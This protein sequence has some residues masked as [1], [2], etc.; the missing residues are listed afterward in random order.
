MH[1][2]QIC[3]CALIFVWYDWLQRWIYVLNIQN[4][5]QCSK[6]NYMNWW[7]DERPNSWPPW[8]VYKIVRKTK[9]G[10][11]KKKHNGLYWLYHVWQVRLLLIMVWES[12]SNHYVRTY[13]ISYF[14]ITFKI[15]IILWCNIDFHC[16]GHH[17]RIRY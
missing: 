1:K 13:I 15:S 17:H 9:W 5:K 8:D 12:L 2:L 3:C 7:T 14:G 6:S 4:V 16:K 11:I 10:F